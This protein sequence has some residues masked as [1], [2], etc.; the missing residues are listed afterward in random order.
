MLA[1][2]LGRL[3][4]REAKLLLRHVRHG[5]AGA[6]L[7]RQ[8]AVNEHAHKLTLHRGLHA[9]SLKS[10]DR[11]PLQHQPLDMQ[12]NLHRHPFTSTGSSQ[13]KS[14]SLIGFSSF[15]NSLRAASRMSGMVTGEPARTARKAALS[16]MLW[17]LPPVRLSRA[18]RWKSTSANGVLGGNMFSQIALR[19]A[20]LGNGKFTMNRKRRRKAL[21]NADFMLV[22]RIARPR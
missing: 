7:F 16:A 2:R 18:R 13:R 17:T 4:R 20:W 10:R 1:D 19:S 22:A 15:R 21:S 6:P 8:T 5:A 3:V 14:A 9:R 12:V 11:Q